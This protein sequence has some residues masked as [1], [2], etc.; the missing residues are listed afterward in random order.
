M[1]RQSFSAGP[2]KYLHNLNKKKLCK[3]FAK[4]RKGKNSVKEGNHQTMKI[5]SSAK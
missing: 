4:E 3:I 1:I 2:C 5:L